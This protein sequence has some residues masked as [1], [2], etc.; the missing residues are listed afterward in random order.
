[1]YSIDGEPPISFFI[2]AL[3]ASDAPPLYNQILFKT[4]TLSRGKHELVVT[5]QGNSGTAP[6]A[7]DAFIVQN[8]SATS[9]P[10]DASSTSSGLPSSSSIS[11]TD[12][13]SNKSSLVAIITGVVSGVIVIVFILIF[14]FGRRYNR[15]LRAQKLKEKSLDTNPDPFTFTRQNTSEL[16]SLTPRPFPRKFFRLGRMERA[17]T[18]GLSRPTP[19]PPVIAARLHSINC[20][21]RNTGRIPVLQPSTSAQGGNLEILQ[22]ADSGTRIQSAQGKLRLV[23]LPPVYTRS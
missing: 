13:F 4:E 20:A 14:Y 16:L 2:P 12:L 3:G 18:P 19:P 11:T 21:A 1:M 23:E 7:L 22:H 15:N 8:A 10:G 17:N 5:Y 9:V 6:F